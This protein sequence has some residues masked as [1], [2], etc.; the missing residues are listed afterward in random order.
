MVSYMTRI[1]RIIWIGY[2][3]T[4]RW[5]DIVHVKVWINAACLAAMGSG[6]SI[7]FDFI[8]K[9]EE[10]KKFTAELQD[11]LSDILANG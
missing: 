9:Y 5:Y 3:T 6:Y 10:L 4:F 8:V 7:R 2:P 1:K 11:E